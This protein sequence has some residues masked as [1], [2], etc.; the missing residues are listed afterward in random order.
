MSSAGPVII[1]PVILCGGAGT[2]LWPVSRQQLPKQFLHLVGDQS[3]LLQTVQRLSG[4]KFAPAIIVSGEDQRTLVDQELRKTDAPI[5]AVLLEPMPRN[6]AAAAGIAA[7]WLKSTNRDEVLLIL[8]SDHVIGERDAFEEAVNVGIPHALEGSIVT[9]GAHPTD[10][11]TQYGY[12]EAKS[13]AKFADGAYR[14]ARFHEKPDAERAAQYVSTGRFFWNCGI[15]LAKASTI[16]DELKTHLPESGKAIAD[17]VAQGTREGQFITPS[18]AAFSEAE[19]ISIDHGIMEKTNRGIV[20]PVQMKWSDIGA[21]D[22]VWK[23]GD[24]DPD[25]N[26]IQGDVVTLDSHNSLLRAN[27][28]AR[29]AAIG[30]QNIAVIAVDDTILIAP[31]DRVAEVKDLLTKVT[32]PEPDGSAASPGSTDAA[33]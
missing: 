20:V 15:F 7:A 19:N 14:I 9:F 21:W 2:R 4:G 32:N 11:N 1:R 8:P 30:L 24:K 16:L 28:H 27:G 33:N 23:L 18:S 12:I 26:V 6:T 31:M 5:E 3:L 17:A 29:I 10:P 13:D 25:G 22:A